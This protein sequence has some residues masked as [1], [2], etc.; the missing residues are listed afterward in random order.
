MCRGGGHPVS[1]GGITEAVRQLGAVEEIHPGDLKALG[2]GPSLL[3]HLCTI[4]WTLGAVLLGAVVPILREG[5]QRACSSYRGVSLLRRPSKV[6]SRV[7][8]RRLCPADEPRVNKMLSPLFAD[9][10]MICV[11]PHHNTD[12]QL[13]GA[14]C[15]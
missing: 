13:A 15:D 1:G 10:V 5:D 7:P 2:G 14:L 12:P 9:D 3:A 11:W 8:E 4:A 6:S